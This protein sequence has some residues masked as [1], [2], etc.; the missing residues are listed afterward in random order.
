M[1]YHSTLADE[2]TIKRPPNA[3][4]A[5]RPE[6]EET[7]SERTR[8]RKPKIPAVIHEKFCNSCA[9]RKNVRGPRLDLSEYSGMEVFDGVPHTTMFSYLRTPINPA[10][11]KSN[12]QAARPP[13]FS[14]REA[15]S[16]A[17]LQALVR[18]HTFAFVLKSQR[19]TA[20]LGFIPGLAEVASSPVGGTLHDPRG[21]SLPVFPRQTSARWS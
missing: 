17:P 6:L 20:T 2:N 1:Q 10:T 4:F 19:G 3:R 21:A 11:L 13:A 8:M 5:S 9:I 16:A 15:S 14:R 7:A 18:R 12:A